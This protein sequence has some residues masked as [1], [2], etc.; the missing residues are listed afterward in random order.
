[1]KD[2]GYRAQEFLHEQLLIFEIKPKKTLVRSDKIGKS[3]CH[4]LVINLSDSSV[5]APC[6]AA[7]VRSHAFQ[8]RRCVKFPPR[9]IISILASFRGK[10]G[11]GRR[12]QTSGSLDTNREPKFSLF[13]AECS[14]ILE[15]GS[16]GRAKQCLDPS[17]AW[18]AQ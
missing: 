17:V 3:H 18:T 11:G 2:G 16:R 6:V 5:S 12:G 4:S 9:I 7:S 1:M 13:T 8:D 10:G 14:R 15:E